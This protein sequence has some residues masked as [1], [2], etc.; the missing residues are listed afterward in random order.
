MNACVRFQAA[1]QQKNTIQGMRAF[2]EE[3]EG[4]RDR[5]KQ[6]STLTT[7]RTSDGCRAESEVAIG[8]SI[9]HKQNEWSVSAVLDRD[10]PFVFFFSLF[11]PLVPSNCALHPGILT[12]PSQAMDIVIEGFDTFPV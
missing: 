4:E 9:S 1:V 5:E 2:D 11:A 3:K 7:F 10:W 8:R 6:G 12:S